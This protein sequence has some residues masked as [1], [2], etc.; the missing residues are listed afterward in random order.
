MKS[1]RRKP[2]YWISNNKVLTG[3]ISKKPH[4]RNPNFETEETKFLIKIWGDPKIQRTLITTHRK[5]PVIQSLADRMRE[6]GYFRSVEEIN[7]RIKNLK[8][9]YNRIK[10]DIDLGIISEPTWKHYSAI[11]EIMNRPMFGRPAHFSPNTS[12]TTNSTINR[13]ISVII[14]NDDDMND[15]ESDEF[16]DDDEEDDITDENDDEN[17][18]IFDGTIIRASDLLEMETGNDIKIEDE[19]MVPKDEPLDVDDDD[20]DDVLLQHNTS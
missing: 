4:I 7:T 19:L 18:G 5:L 20:D 2:E 1:S 14:E 11:D 12:T 13:N 8:C 16:D 3:G 15:N 6:K 9:L 10:K 17:D